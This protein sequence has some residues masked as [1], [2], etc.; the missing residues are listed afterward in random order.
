MFIDS[1]CHLDRLK[2]EDFDNNLDNVVNAALAE[3]VNT[4]LCVSVTLEDFPAMAEATAKYDNVWLTCGAHP[5]NQA[6]EIDPALLTRLATQPR[7]VA[8]GE[9]G[10]DYFYAPETKQVQLDSFRKHIRVANQLKKPLIIHTRGAQE[11]TLAMLRSEQAEN[12]GGILHCFT[13]SWQMAEQA[14]TMGFYI[15]FSGIVTFKNAT[16]L[17]EVAKKVPSDRFLIETD[18]PY[19]APVPH[20][21]KQNQPAYVVEVAKHLASIRGTSVAEIARQSSENFHRLFPETI[22]VK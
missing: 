3:K 11:D 15:S 10:L 12:V 2:L 9:T 21:G 20:R 4:L 6:D 17:R 13:E 14:I 8:I 19:L 16:D 18:A 5:L 7:V 1:H 22:P